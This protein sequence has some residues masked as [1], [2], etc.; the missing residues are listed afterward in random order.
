MTDSVDE[1]LQSLDLILA[2]GDDPASP[3]SGRVDGEHVAAVGHSAGGGT[4]LA[5]AA[6]DRIDGYVGMASGRHDESTDM[7]S[8]PSL[9]VAG[10][11]D[12]LMS[13]EEITRPAYEA[14]PSPSTLWVIEAAGHNA[15]DDFCTFGNGTGIIGLAE[16]S[17]LGAFLDGA[18]QLRSLGEDGC[19]PPA[20]PVDSTFPIIRHVVTAW[21]LALFGTEPAT[22]LGPEVAGAYVTPVVIEQ[23]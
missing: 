18:P 7:P 21:V 9:F 10:S 23:K 3:F 5:A 17:G 11:L 20:L 19:L 14:A 15:F 22:G 1:L 4:V 2:A 13:A 12:G 16:A 6:D 8:K